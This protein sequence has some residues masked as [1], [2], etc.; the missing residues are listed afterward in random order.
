MF[1]TFIVRQLVIN[2]LKLKT[3]EFVFGKLSFVRTKSFLSDEE[4]MLE[5]SELHKL[6]MAVNRQAYRGCLQRLRTF[7]KISL[8]PNR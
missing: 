2:T 8:K 1:V 5:K 7:F 3:A 4:L 6:A